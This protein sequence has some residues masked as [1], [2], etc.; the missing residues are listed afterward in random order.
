TFART[1]GVRDYQE[2]VVTNNVSLTGLDGTSYFD[3]SAY[4]FLVQESVDFQDRQA[5]VTPQLNYEKTLV[6]GDWG[7]F[8]FVARGSNIF[9]DDED[10]LLVPGDTKF[11]GLQG[12]AAR[13][14]SEFIWSGKFTGGGLV[15]KPLLAARGDFYSYET[16]SAAGIA[17]SA[18]GVAGMV[19]A[20][21]E[22][23][24]PLLITAPGSTHI[25]EP[26]AQIYA[27]PNERLAGQLPNNDAHSIIF[28][29]TSLFDRD[30]FNAIDRVEGGTRLN[31]GLRYSA[32][33]DNGVTLAATAGQ[34]WHVA[35]LNSYAVQ[36]PSNA[37]AST[38]L[39]NDVSDIVAGLSAGF[40]KVASADLRARYDQASLELA[41]LEAEG[42]LY[43]KDL[44][45]TLGYTFIRQQP[46][47]GFTSNRHELS[48]GMRANLT[49]NWVVG[50]GASYDFS[51]GS[52]VTSSA[53]LGYQADAGYFGV[54]YRREEPGYT[55]NEINQSFEFE[56]RLFPFE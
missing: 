6:Q 24:Y 39:E 5:L 37:T 35:G 28:D 12:Q 36:D 17:N 2:R 3:L 53:T 40:G 56:V 18:T 43:S 23:S 14:S 42:T 52:F 16:A 13:L 47:V 29:S 7:K 19:T 55:T 8:Q 49:E 26:V 22:V 32:A 20:G 30:K 31:Y 1:Y 44:D 34:S 33:F 38:G 4:Q 27:R 46:L 51:G 15:F 21:L 25:I 45:L 50:L 11:E 54:N 41:R 9:R 48:G 10:T